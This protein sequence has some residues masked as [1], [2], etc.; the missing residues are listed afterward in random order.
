MNVL[1]Q[2][3]EADMTALAGDLSKLDTP[4]PNGTAS[5]LAEDTLDAPPG[6]A[7]GQL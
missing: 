6:L 3:E 1:I 4:A 5:S 7:A 2:D